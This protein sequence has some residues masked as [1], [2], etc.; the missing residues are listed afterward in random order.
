MN[1]EL[2]RKV[3][4]LPG[5]QFTFPSDDVKHHK[6]HA[7]DFSNNVASFDETKPGIGGNPLDGQKHTPRTSSKLYPSNA[8]DGQSVPAWVAF[9]RQVLRFDGY[10]REAVHE[11]RE[12]NYR[13]RKCEILFYLEDDSIQV[14]EHRVK[15]SG[16][17][18][19]TLIRRHRIAK[20]STGRPG[21]VEQFYTVEDFNLQSTLDLYSR[22][23]VITDCDAFTK[24]FLTKLGVC[25]NTP[26]NMPSDPYTEMRNQMLAAMKPRRPYM[27]EDTLKQFLNND[28]KVLRFA[29]VWDDR[30]SV[31]G[32][33]RRMILHYYLADDT[34]EIREEIPINSGRDAVSHFLKRQRLTKHGG[35]LGPGER[36]EDFYTDQDLVIGGHVNVYGRPFI[37]LN[38]DEFT[39][40]YYRSKYAD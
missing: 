27:K 21:E 29:C 25:V 13:I 36:P 23:F 8:E 7:F 22:M 20:P 18:Q 17:P 39:K 16:I 2:A 12:E 15:N 32:D 40:E 28:R 19:G 3:P 37:I 33:K 6:A 31:F 24:N 5:H 35:N 26:I 11:K 4:C 10:F 30:D 14:T 38:C 1:D 9:D 34:I